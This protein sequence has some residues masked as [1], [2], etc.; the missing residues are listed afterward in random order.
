MIRKV[1]YGM[2]RIGTITTAIGLI[3]YG[4]WLAARNVQS[5]IA[6][7]MFR[8]W[9]V[10]FIILG[11]EILVFT[12]KGIENRR[13]FNAGIVFV[14]L[15]F[16]FTNIFYDVPGSIKKACNSFNYNGNFIFDSDFNLKRIDVS[17]S[18]NLVNNKF[19]FK[20]NN[21]DIEIKKSSDENVKAD[22]SVYVDKDSNIGKYDINNS[23]TS[24]ETKLDIE[25]NYV[26]KVTGTLYVPD[27]ADVQI[28]VNNLNV[29][30]DDDLKNTKFNVKSNNGKFDLCNAA[31]LNL[32]FSNGAVN[33]KDIKTVKLKGNNASFKLNGDIENIDIQNNNG[34]INID[35]NICN[36][37]NIKSNNSTIKLD[38]QD[39]NIDADLSIDLGVCVF[40]DEKV[41]KG[42]IKK[43]VGDGSH[44]VKISTS[45]GSIKVTSQE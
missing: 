11:L 28:D 35:N 38:T 29:N 21:G 9:P 34:A 7:Y 40:N 30:S 5:E 20:A 26:K 6:D 44:K 43:S 10:I 31:E 37:V 23:G 33:L 36:N 1:Y 8:F 41:N 39:K 27:G 45:L 14:L 17:K 18:L 32:D 4:I 42:E 12:K 24:D 16:L 3:Y 25:E 2:R 13:G 15:L 22:L 19:Y